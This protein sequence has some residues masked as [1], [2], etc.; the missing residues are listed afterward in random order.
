[1]PYPVMTRGLMFDV[2]R[3][4]VLKGPQGDLYGRNTTGGAINFISNKPTDAFEASI[5]GEYGSYDQARLEGNLSGPLSDSLRGRVSGV[6]RRS[7]EGWMDSHTRSDDLGE[8]DAGAVRL[9]LD[10]GQ[11]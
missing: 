8:V 6:F 4:E 1:M 11:R 7:G 2:E 3:V 9:L 10:W 5:T